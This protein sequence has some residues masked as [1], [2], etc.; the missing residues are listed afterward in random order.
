VVADAGFGFAD[1]ETLTEPLA[2][3]FSDP[4]AALAWTLTWPDY[5]WTVDRLD[6][7]QRPA[8]ERE[9]LQ[10]IADAGDL[11]WEFAINLPRR[12]DFGRVA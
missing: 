12:D 9:A 2:G 7:E 11:S 1:I 5:G 8:F 10:A 4:D 6:T 3:R